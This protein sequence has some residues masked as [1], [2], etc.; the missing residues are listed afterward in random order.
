M[1]K[2]KGLFTLDEWRRQILPSLVKQCREELLKKGA[3][4]TRGTRVKREA[5]LACV[6]EK[7]RKIREE[8]LRQITGG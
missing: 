7:A 8:R 3:L 4:G 2:Y 1:S 6:R 5:L